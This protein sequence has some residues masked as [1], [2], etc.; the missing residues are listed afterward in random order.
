VEFSN[1][2]TLLSGTGYTDAI[3]APEGIAIDASSRTW[4]ADSG[5]NP[6]TYLVP[7]AGAAAHTTFNS[8][9]PPINSL[10]FLL[11]P[12]CSLIRQPVFNLQR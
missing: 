3:F 5:T 12:S 7:R 10:E 11:S 8:S 2:Q 4:I 6:A 1:T 9:C